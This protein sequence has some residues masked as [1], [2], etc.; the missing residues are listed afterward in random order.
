MYEFLFPL[1]N[2]IHLTENL[3]FIISKGLKPNLLP[4][5]KRI[6]TIKVEH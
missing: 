2:I 1:D 3:I 4:F 5:L 6:T